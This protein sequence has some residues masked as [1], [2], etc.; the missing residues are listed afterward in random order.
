MKISFISVLFSTAVVFAEA[1]KITLKQSFLA[2]YVAQKEKVKPEDV[3][4]IIIKK[5]KSFNHGVI[6]LSHSSSCGVGLC[7]YYVFVKNSA[8]SFDFAGH[9]EGVYQKTKSIKGSD[10]PEIMTQTQSGD[11]KSKVVSWMFNAEK[12]VYEAQ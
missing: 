12:K 8:G 9:I 7:S 2:D 10:L 1:A 3:R 6:L 5:D 4:Q 11:V